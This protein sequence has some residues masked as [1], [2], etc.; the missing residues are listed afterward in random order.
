MKQNADF[1]FF[2]LTVAC[3]RLSDCHVA[4]AIVFFFRLKA[5]FVIHSFTAR[6]AS[7]SSA[8]RIR[9]LN[10]LNNLSSPHISL[11]LIE[12]RLFPSRILRNSKE[13]SSFRSIRRFG[14][15]AS[16]P[17]KKSQTPKPS[18]ELVLWHVGNRSL[19]TAQEVIQHIEGLPD[20]EQPAAIERLRADLVR[21]T[22]TNEQ[23]LHDIYSWVIERIE[24]GE[25]N[26]AETREA[27]RPIREAHTRVRNRRREGRD[28]LAGEGKW[29]TTAFWDDVVE[30]LTGASGDVTDALRKIKNKGLKPVEV[31]ERGCF[32][33]F[34][35]LSGESTTRFR[36]DKFC[37]GGDLKTAN[38]G[39]LT[40]GKLTPGRFFSSGLRDYMTLDEHG[41]LWH[42]PLKASIAAT[43]QEQRELDKS[44]AGE[45]I[46]PYNL[47]KRQKKTTDED[48]INAVS[49]PEQTLTP[50]FKKPARGRSTPRARKTSEMD[51]IFNQLNVVKTKT[52]RQ[53]A[54][55]LKRSGKSAEEWPSPERM[56]IPV[57]NSTPRQGAL[58]EVIE[59][60]VKG[61]KDRRPVDISNEA[62][63]VMK[64]PADQ[65]VQ[66]V[67]GIATGLSKVSTSEDTLL[68]YTQCLLDVFRAQIAT[69]KGQTDEMSELRTI[70]G[71][72]HRQYRNQTVTLIP[73]SI[74]QGG[75]QLDHYD[76]ATLLIGEGYS[77]WLNGDLI[78][79]ILNITADRANQY[80]VPAR[81]FDFWHQGNHP[82]NIFYVP[83]NHPSLIVMVHWGN[84]WAIMIA[85]RS[86]GR[87]HYLD[88]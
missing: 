42:H 23:A 72:W 64:L 48:D 87:I 82:D 12:F 8:R 36:K 16:M 10:S 38:L 13:F 41:F 61:V 76:L 75:V 2:F 39:Q 83:D 63:Q 43:V 81:A 78:H 34:K 50:S 3:T 44:V 37:T 69:Q 7:Q 29:C 22:L 59:K 58:W 30:P 46:A 52:A 40:E 47:R 25:L 56:A 60:R 85:D 68:V 77:G 45:G 67:E 18:Q 19:R 5:R 88:S 24:A 31:M 15:F 55:S 84:H 79:G 65:L 57:K 32:E 49:D 6:E 62:A 4:Q 1:L 20:L 70:I 21:V 53:R 73:G 9:S 27:W 26:S 71:T 17:P 11:A 51:K 74:N 86:D 80:I 14:L 54:A 35:R 28:A 66:E 33:M